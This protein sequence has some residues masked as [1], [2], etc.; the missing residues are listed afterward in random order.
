MGNAQSDGPPE[1]TLKV[2]IRHR[3]DMRTCTLGGLI[4]ADSSGARAYEKGKK[5]GA[6]RESRG[7]GERVIR[8]QM[9]SLKF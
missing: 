9:S 5:E 3:T 7:G 2:H 1:T 4:R 8:E 6:E